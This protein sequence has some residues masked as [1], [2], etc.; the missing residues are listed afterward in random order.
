MGIRKV[1]KSLNGAPHA[2]AK[3]HAWADSEQQAEDTRRAALEHDYAT[4]L[5]IRREGERSRLAFRCKCGAI[6]RCESAAGDS[7]EHATIA[8][9]LADH[10]A[11]YQESDTA[12]IASR[13]AGY[14]FMVLATGGV[15]AAWVGRSIADLGRIIAQEVTVK[16]FD[17]EMIDSRGGKSDAPDDLVAAILN[18]ADE[19]RLST[20]ER[21]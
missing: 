7:A 8:N 20:V 17:I 18:V 21:K 5:K 1:R 14:T 11:A 4:C 3:F 10:A 2:S 19:Y 12:I 16:T 13:Y 9:A 6:I 15:L